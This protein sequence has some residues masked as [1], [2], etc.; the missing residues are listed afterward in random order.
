MFTTDDEDT[1]D[2]VADLEELDLL[3]DSMQEIPIFD[4]DGNRI[5]RRKATLALDNDGL[6]HGCGLLQDLSLVR[7]LFEQPARNNNGGTPEDNRVP[8]WYFP[9]FFSEKYGQWQADGVIKAMLPSVDKINQALR[10]HEGIGM[11]VE[12]VRSQCYNAHDTRASARL[13]VAQRGML[14]ATIGGAWEGNQKGARTA[15]NLFNQANWSLPHERLQAQT[16]KVA[17][18][19]L[20]LEEEFVFHV[21]RFADQHQTGRGFFVEAIKPIIDAGKR[22]EVLKDLKKTTVVF[23]PQVSSPPYPTTFPID[24]TP[25]DLASHVLGHHVSGDVPHSVV[26]GHA[27]QGRSSAT[28]FRPRSRPD[29]HPFN[30]SHAHNPDAFLLGVDR[31]SGALP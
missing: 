9:H 20:R 29:R 14:T 1:R 15:K 18:T 17:K 3:D 10:A 25:S 7:T 6:A 2:E 4:V 23:K 13:H 11:C 31:R 19:F 26:M 21:T 28:R 30:G 5:P 8:L 16:D 24:N 22:S 12:P 27:P